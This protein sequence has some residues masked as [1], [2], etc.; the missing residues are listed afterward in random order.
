MHRENISIIVDSSMN[1]DILKGK[2]RTSKELGLRINKQKTFLTFLM[3]RV[4]LQWNG[5]DPT[6]REI[7]QAKRKHLQNSSIQR[8]VGQKTSKMI[9]KFTALI[10]WNCFIV[11]TF[12]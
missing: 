1:N 3:V 6:S 12:I 11:D 9:T 4:I 10:T 7:N 2:T 8:E 5:L